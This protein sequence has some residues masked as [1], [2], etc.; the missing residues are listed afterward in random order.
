M[1]RNIE[2]EA[3]KIYLVKEKGLKA[4]YEELRTEVSNTGDSY[5][6]AFFKMMPQS[7][8]SKAKIRDIIAKKTRILTKD[9]AEI[10][11][12]IPATPKDELEP[13]ELGP[14]D[15]VPETYKSSKSRHTIE[16]ADE[17]YEGKTLPPAAKNLEQKV[18]ITGPTKTL[19][20]AKDKEKRPAQEQ[21][22]TDGTKTMPSAKKPSK[23]EEIANAGDPTKSMP[24][25]PSFHLESAA[26]AS[27]IPVVGS[28]EIK[29]ASTKKPYVSKKQI[30]TGFDKF[31]IQEK[32]SEGGMGAVFIA[33]DQDTN[34]TVVL[35]VGK[36]TDPDAQ[37]RFQKE[38]EVHAQIE[39]DNVA[40]IYEGGFTT[41]ETIVPPKKAGERPT[42][43]PA[44][45]PFF[46]MKMLHGQPLS[47]LIDKMNENGIKPDVSQILQLFKGACYGVK[48]MHDKGLIHRD[49][50]P[51]NLW[52]AYEKKGEEKLLVLDLGLAKKIKEV[53]TDDVTKKVHIS[54]EADM[55]KTLEGA[56]AGTI[57]YMSPE[58]AEGKISELDERSDIYALGAILYEMITLDTMI[59]PSGGQI[60]ALNRVMTQEIT[61][62]KLI[63]K[64]VLAIL[65]KMLERDKTERYKKLGQVIT[66]I[67]KYSAGKP[68]SARK[69]NPIE[70]LGKWYTRNK[71]FTIPA[72]IALLGITT[73]GAITQTLSVKASRAEAAAATEQAGREK[74]EKE[75]AKESAKAEKALKEK[76]Q[77]DAEVIK[78]EKEKVMVAIQVKEETDIK[79]NKANKK[80]DCGAVYYKNKDYDRAIAE[81]TA[82]INVY[83][84]SAGAHYSR[85]F[86]LRN[87]AEAHLNK[88]YINETEKQVKEKEAKGILKQSLEDMI[89]AVELD[90]ENTMYLMELAQAQ[91][92][93]GRNDEAEKQFEAAIKKAEQNKE[94]PHPYVLLNF[95]AFYSRTNRPTQAIE[96]YKEYLQD[97]PEDD[98]SAYAAIA[99][100]YCDLNNYSEAQKFVDIAL[101]DK[102]YY[103]AYFEQG[104]IYYNRG[105]DAY[106][107]REDAEAK[108]LL[109]EAEKYLTLALTY[110]PQNAKRIETM[111]T[112]IKQAF[113][114]MK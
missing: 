79:R 16:D 82:A 8:A 33:L 34:R 58:Q 25:A 76:A 98:G 71:I 102:K 22:P 62:P 77:A 9:A 66:D 35:K 7:D 37:S 32:L 65:K 47:K 101:N 17:L 73:I 112:Q 61:W 20:P 21:Y 88:T 72:T 60:N 31:I 4:E 86:A 57:L 15:A 40:P 84:E 10:V 96:K 107:K 91:E 50:K 49:L 51:D 24:P 38:K 74:A 18:D 83:P 113:S 19:P 56:I 41:K 28:E 44:G 106:K 95:G 78:K 87:K 3:W 70:L 2:A 103:G 114:Q 92:L 26:E 67:E 45:V 6:K 5:D 46:A 36:R 29:E 90:S 11:E 27:E 39:D 52:H 59:D 68:V 109:F 48:A 14:E 89:R 85:A 42:K 63:P 105:N 23:I 97:M 100:A 12:T 54:Q 93:V 53:A 108:K 64:D 43:I 13:V 55:K 1:E 69:Y 104:K 81:Y 30:G 80:I 75:T 99:N 94:K 111:R 110:I